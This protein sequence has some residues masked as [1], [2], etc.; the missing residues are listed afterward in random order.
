MLWEA[1]GVEDR[2]IAV[3]CDRM[4]MT[5][6]EPKQ[7]HRSAHADIRASRGWT[8]DSADAYWSR[9][10]EVGDEYVTQEA[11]DD[12]LI[13][14]GESLQDSASSAASDDTCSD[15]FCANSNA[16]IFNKTRGFRLGSSNNSPY[17]SKQGQN[18]AS[19]TPSRA[20]GIARSISLPDRG[21]R[22]SSTIVKGS[23][24][25]KSDTRSLT[26]WPIAQSDTRLVLRYHPD[27]Q[28]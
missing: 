6:V 27:Q 25:S 1:W 3:G 8:M 26:A 28:G 5:P 10:E 24:K 15:D 11:S 20:S 4:T 19:N 12:D 21:S 18:D 17:P 16:R 7:A 22:M 23:R 14:D 2:H 9:Y 13:T